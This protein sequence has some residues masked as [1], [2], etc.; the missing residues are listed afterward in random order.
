MVENT[1]CNRKI[2]STGEQVNKPILIESFAFRVALEQ[3]NET[4]KIKLKYS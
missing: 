3:V 2:A 1:S 4:G